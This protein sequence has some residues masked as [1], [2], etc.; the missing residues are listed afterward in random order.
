MVGE[1]TVEG[2]VS[3]DRGMGM[4]GARRVTGKRMIGELAR[5][6]RK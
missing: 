4:A 2:L 3:G 6:A 5:S 1:V